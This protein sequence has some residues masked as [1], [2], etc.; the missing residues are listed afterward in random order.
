MTRRERTRRLIE[1]G[2]LVT[3]AGI[4]E[5]TG[6][7]RAVIYGA[8]LVI[9]EMLRDDDRERALALWGRKGRRAF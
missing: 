6:D 2:G 5:L 7:D 8:F 9:A 3:K 1:L 4:V